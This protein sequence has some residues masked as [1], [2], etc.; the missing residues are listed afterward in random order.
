MK[1][2]VLMAMTAFF[3]TEAA[4]AAESVARLNCTTRFE[5]RVEQAEAFTQEGVADLKIPVFK[6]RYDATSNKLFMTIYFN[7]D[8]TTGRIVEPVPGT[9]Y[10]LVLPKTSV[11][12]VCQPTRDPYTGSIDCPDGRYV[13]ESPNLAMSCRVT[14]FVA[15]E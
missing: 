2:Q 14:H 15:A 6:A 7:N 11:M 8:F 12:A 3:A 1:T 9:T 4:S 5:D 10:D 13:V